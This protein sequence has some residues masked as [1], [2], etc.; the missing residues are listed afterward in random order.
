MS[1]ARP[2]QS[3]LASRLFVVACAALAV[4][5]LGAEAACFEDWW[6]SRLDEALEMADSPR[7]MLPI[8]EVLDS[9]FTAA[10]PEEIAQALESLRTAEGVDPLV[11]AEIDGALLTFDL[12]RGRFERAAERRARLGTIDH[13]LVAGPLEDA[14]R[15]LE[16]ME[17][18]AEGLDVTP[19]RRAASDPSGVLP[20]HYAMYPQSE[21]MALAVFY[22]RAGRD[23]AVALRFGADD[24]AEVRLN[25]RTLFARPEKHDLAFDQSEVLLY[26][27]EGLNRV[28]FLV[29]QDDN[30]WLLRAR[31]SAPD[32]SPDP[33]ANSR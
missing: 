20:L 11:A 21:R 19:W 12:R 24:R 9:A 25:G 30:A 33:V 31:I 32:G 5:G 26:L 28:T 23:T 1:R 29:E 13:W 6:S 7:A 4:L 10:D 16:M 2:S 3:A 8:R 27:D 14:T 15:R 17:Q 18:L 22:L